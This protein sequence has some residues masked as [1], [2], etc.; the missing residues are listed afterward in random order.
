M[1]ATPALVQSGS[2]NAATAGPALPGSLTTA[3]GNL[4][5]L[6]IA[7]VGSSTPTIGTPAGWTLIETRAFGTTFTVATFAFANNPG[8]ATNPS[9]TL[10]GTVTGWIA[11]M[12][13]FSGVGIVSKI[14]YASL[15][16]S[17]TAIP[18]AFVQGSANQ[19]NNTV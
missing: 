4:L 13:E 2:A 18:N 12:F 5:I 1:A 9:S 15:I 16:Y 19:G 11:E 17:Q 8:G 10:G 7:V 3:T 14:G 6:V